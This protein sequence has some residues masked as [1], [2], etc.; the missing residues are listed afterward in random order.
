MLALL[1]NRTWL[2]EPE[3]RL[4]SAMAQNRRTAIDV[5]ANK[6]LYAFHLARLFGEV[7]AFEPLPEMSRFLSRA[8]P[9][10]VKVFP[11]AA[12]DTADSAL[13]RMPE[14]L[15]E[16]SSLEPALV[17]RSAHG[18][19]F[20]TFAVPRQT[21]DSFAFKSVDL[22]KIDVEGHESAVLRGAI[23]TI[24]ACRPC[25]MVAIEDYHRP[26]AV[27]EVKAFLEDLGYLGFFFDNAGIRSMDTFD[28]V[29]DQDV[30][31]LENRTTVPALRGQFHVLPERACGRSPAGPCRIDQARRCACRTWRDGEIEVYAARGVRVSPVFKLCASWRT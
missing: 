19:R 24:T 3:I 2:Q 15:D 11:V 17:D 4:L 8:A 7:F 5:G 21:I 26:G 20:H 27:A 1:A 28:L 13:L 12:S 22:I 31:N 18:T 29:R 9:A 16:L 6:G 30:A 25:L 14:G 23:R 10:N